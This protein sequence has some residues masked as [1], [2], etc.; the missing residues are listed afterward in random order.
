MY[1]S[2]NSRKAIELVSLVGKAITVFTSAGI[3]DGDERS[4]WE[5]N[6]AISAAEEKMWI[7]YKRIQMIITDLSMYFSM[8]SRKTI[9]I[10]SIVRKA[11]TVFTSA[12]N[13]DGDECS[14]WEANHAVLAAEE[15]K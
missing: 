11:M 6:H 2:M 9:E 8:N 13:R 4:I 14:N 7:W 12:G 1:F 10:Q 15:K 3:R 5:A